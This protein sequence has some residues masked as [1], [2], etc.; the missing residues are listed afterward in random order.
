MELA[1]STILVN[2]K[3]DAE[4]KRQ[5]DAVLARSGKTASELI[6]ALYQH[7]AMTRR[8]PDFITRQGA[9]ERARRQH[10]LELLLSAI[11]PGNS[12]DANDD[13]VLLEEL[14]RRHA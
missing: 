12:D 9:D 10:A 3:V 2:G 1:M 14:E 7:I 11:V 4:V 13:K 5:T 8:L 6:R